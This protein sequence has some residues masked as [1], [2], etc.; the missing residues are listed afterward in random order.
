L[1]TPLQ[2]SRPVGHPPGKRKIASKDNTESSQLTVSD[3]V[4]II[5]S[6]H[7][8]LENLLWEKNPNKPQDVE[9]YLCRQ[10]GHELKTIYSCL[11]CKKAF[12]VNCF[13]AF[14]FQGGLSHSHQTLLQVAFSSEKRPRITHGRNYCPKSLADL[15]SPQD[16]GGTLTKIR[17]RKRIYN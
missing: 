2:N 1:I 10:M 12:H 15:K 3:T 16:K 17:K 14:H 8:L 4:C 5:D 13:T 6:P 9:C 7:M 11:V